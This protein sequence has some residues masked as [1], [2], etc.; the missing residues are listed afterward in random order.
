MAAFWRISLLI[1]G[2]ADSVSYNSCKHSIDS[3]SSGSS[4]VEVE[5]EAEV[6]VEVEAEVE[7][8]VE[9]ATKACLDWSAIEPLLQ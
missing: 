5:V 9:V 1:T 3:S 6:E 7:V 4:E 2:G 8:E